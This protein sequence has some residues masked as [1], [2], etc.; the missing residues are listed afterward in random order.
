MGTCMSVDE[1]E[2]I[3]SRQQIERLPEGPKKV[4]ALQQLNAREAEKTSQ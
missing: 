3:M 1:E 2:P 4:A